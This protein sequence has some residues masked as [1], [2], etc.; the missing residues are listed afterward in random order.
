[1]NTKLRTNV[2]TI[3][4]ACRISSLTVNRFSGFTSIMPR[5]RFWQSGGTKCGIWKT[6]FFTFSNNCRKLSSSNGN[7]PTSSAYSITPHDQTSAFLPSYFS[8]CKSHERITRP[9]ADVHHAKVTRIDRHVPAIVS[10]PA[11]VNNK[12]RRYPDRSGNDPGWRL[13]G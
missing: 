2:T 1:M 13:C 11:N 3:G 6:P 10:V 5:S 7:A 8:P 9:P 12:H 4:F